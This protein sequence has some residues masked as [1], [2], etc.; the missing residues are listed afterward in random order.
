MA[1]Q[2][3]ETSTPARPPALPL[4]SSQAQYE[5]WAAEHT[6]PAPDAETVR[7]MNERRQ[8]SALHEDNE[9]RRNAWPVLTV[10]S[11]A[12]PDCGT[13]A[14]VIYKVKRDDGPSGEGDRPVTLE[15]REPHRAGQTVTRKRSR[16][17]P[18]KE[19]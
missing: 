2:R 11:L 16:V 12:R 7:A 17:V 14:H 4:G 9:R 10:G 6:P 3:H 18:V 8:E 13:D 1:K 19:N 15:R 5:R